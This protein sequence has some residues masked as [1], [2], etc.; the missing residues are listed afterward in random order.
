MP[1]TK[2]EFDSWAASMSSALDAID[3]APAESKAHIY[4]FEEPIWNMQPAGGTVEITDAYGYN[5]PHVALRLEGN[6]TENLVGVA[7]LDATLGNGMFP[8]IPDEAY[9]VSAWVNADDAE[10]DTALLIDVSSWLA[11]VVQLPLHKSDVTGSGWQLVTIG[12]Y[13]NTR[14]DEEPFD[15]THDGTDT[16]VL[17]LAVSAFNNSGHGTGRW[18]VD[19][20]RIS[21]SQDAAFT[22]AHAPAESLAVTFKRAFSSPVTT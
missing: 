21:S 13:T 18:L 15:A 10:E 1:M 3:A 9:T 2:E 17:S 8:T 5:T 16:V 14:L 11:S 20:V 12:T 7:V 4:T 22:A 19:S 6:D